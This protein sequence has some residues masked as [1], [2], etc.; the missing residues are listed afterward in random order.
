MKHKKRMNLGWL[1]WD[2]TCSPPELVQGL[3]DFSVYICCCSP[4]RQSPV[5]SVH[6]F[7]VQKLKLNVHCACSHFFLVFLFWCMQEKCASV[8]GQAEDTCGALNSK[9]PTSSHD[10]KT[11]AFTMINNQKC[12][13]CW[14]T[15]NFNHLLRETRR[16]RDFAKFMPAHVAAWLAWCAWS[17]TV[18]L[19]AEW[20]L[21][22]RQMFILTK[23]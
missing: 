12:L 16:F 8:V 20:L 5:H 11:S 22:W 13:C 19:C 15:Q 2:N 3:T 14:H 1:F 10:L 9:K 21:T 7:H 17:S 4:V 6:L 23:E 18:S